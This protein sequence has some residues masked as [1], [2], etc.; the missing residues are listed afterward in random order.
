MDFEE[1]LK[2]VKE[3]K[4]KAQKY[5]KKYGRPIPLVSLSAESQWETILFKLD[6]CGYKLVKKEKK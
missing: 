5:A 1:T 4:E 6:L 2:E 3:I